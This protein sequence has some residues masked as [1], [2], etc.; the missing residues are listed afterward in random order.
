MCVEIKLKCNLVSRS[1]FISRN[2]DLKL[3]HGRFT[4]MQM[5]KAG[6]MTRHCTADDD[7]ITDRD[8]YNVT[9]VGKEIGGTGS[10]YDGDPTER[11]PINKYNC[12]W[13]KFIGTFSLFRTCQ[14]V[15]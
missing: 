2:N 1:P 5:Y 15:E 3:Q 4:L 10:T 11:A 8:K 6:Q 14:L 7:D 9:K 12:E 13:G